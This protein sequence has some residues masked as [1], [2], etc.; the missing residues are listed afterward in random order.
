LKFY[1]VAADQRA[2]VFSVIADSLDD[3][4]LRFRRSPRSHLPIFSVI[5][6]ET[7]IYLNERT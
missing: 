6:T 7:E 3:A 2:I 4:W 1:F 5:K